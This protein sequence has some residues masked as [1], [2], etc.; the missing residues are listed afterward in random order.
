MTSSIENQLSGTENVQKS[1]I[2]NSV[3]SSTDSMKLKNVI[4]EKLWSWVIIVLILVAIGGAIELYRWYSDSTSPIVIDNPTHEAIVVTLD[5]NDYAIAAGDHVEATLPFGEWD[6]E[7]FVD[8]KSVWSF[9]KQIRDG[10]S[11]INP[12]MSMYIKERYLYSDDD[13]AAEVALAQWD[14]EDT[15]LCIDGK[16]YDWWYNVAV[17]TGLYIPKDRDYGIDEDS[18]STV[19]MSESTKYETKD[20]LFRKDQLID[21]YGTGWDAFA[22]C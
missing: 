21:S 22:D 20:E 14:I 17:Y 1:P 6:Y 8:H 11:I 13:D 16:E 18:P 10:K 9:H 3:S 4:I 19:Y 5:H 15:S 7:V 2:T 12:T